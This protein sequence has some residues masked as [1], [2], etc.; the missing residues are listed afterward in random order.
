MKQ[1]DFTSRYWG[2][3]PVSDASILQKILRPIKKIAVALNIVPK[4]MG[5][6]KILKK[7]IFGDLVK[8]PAEISANTTPYIRPVEINDN[9]PDKNHKVIF[10]AAT[11]N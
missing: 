8:M 1:N 6:K 3:T 10:C 9:E 2:D 4:S 5:A 7:F 11:M